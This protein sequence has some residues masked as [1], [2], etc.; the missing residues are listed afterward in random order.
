MPQSDYEAKREKRKK[1]KGR[2]EALLP[3]RRVLK[4]AFAART[5]NFPNL[6]QTIANPTSST[7]YSGSSQILSPVKSAFSRIPHRI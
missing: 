6:R 5:I 3:A 1:G 4:F 7:R 2:V